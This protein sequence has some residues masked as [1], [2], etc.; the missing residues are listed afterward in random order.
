LAT[1]CRRLG[2]EPEIETDRKCESE[3][4]G[5]FEFANRFTPS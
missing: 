3:P 4:I 2:N 5:K 1:P